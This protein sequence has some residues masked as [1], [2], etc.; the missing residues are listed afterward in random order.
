MPVIGT[1]AGASATGFGGLRTFGSVTPSAF[2]SIATVSVSSATSS[3]EFTSIPSTY[4]HLQVRAFM[5][6]S[7]TNNMYM[8]LGNGSIDSGSNYSWKQLWG[9][10]TNANS[11]DGQSQGFFYIGYVASTTYPAACI[12]D[13]A[14]Y[15]NTNKFKTA[16]A[17]NA[18][19]NNTAGYVTSFSGN[20]RSSSA[21]DRVKITTGS[22]TFNQYSH[23]ALYGIKNT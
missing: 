3:I 19:N 16:K 13:I 8:Q 12:I 17:I 10:G 1:L 20:W 9:E 4:T 15:A 2:E 7:S 22:G 6:C 18:N 21:V 5:V 14:D 11:N 23:F